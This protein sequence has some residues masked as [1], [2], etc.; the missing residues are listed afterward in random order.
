MKPIKKYSILFILALVVICLSPQACNPTDEGDNDIEEELTDDTY[1][2]DLYGIPKFV[3]TNYIELYKIYRISKFRSGYGHDY[4]DDFESCRS[5]KHYFQPRNSVN[6]SSVG[7]YSPVTGTISEL[8]DGWAG[9]QVRIRSDQYPAFWF[10]LFHVNLSVSL[11]IGD[12]VTA[13]EKLGNHIGS[14]TMSDIAIG[15][16]TPHGWKLI[17]YFEVMTDPLFQ[18][19]QVRGVNNRNQLIISMQARDADPL[20]CQGETFINSGNLEHWFILN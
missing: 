19:Y 12:A 13:G 3:N 18:N 8:K 2:V 17:S 14:Q 5:M 15:V 10:I 1:D 20:T 7:I 9:T 4:S 6:W 11:N 16:N